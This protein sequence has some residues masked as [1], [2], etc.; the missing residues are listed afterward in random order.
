MSEH[1]SS[2]QEKNIEKM[3]EIVE[4]KNEETSEKQDSNPQEQKNQSLKDS[5]RI[6]DENNKLTNSDNNR[7]P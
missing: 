6:P 5:A 2:Q 7:N 3:K 1:Q 4:E